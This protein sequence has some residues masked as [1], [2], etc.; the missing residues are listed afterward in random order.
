MLQGL[1]QIEENSSYGVQIAAALDLRKTLSKI[2]TDAILRSNEWLPRGS[3]A[4]YVASLL[5]GA[6]AV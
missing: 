1:S 6:C 4:Y 2:E 3:Y 5:F